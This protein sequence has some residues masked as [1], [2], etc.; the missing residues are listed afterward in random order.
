MGYFLKDE[1]SMAD[2]QENSHGGGLQVCGV[3]CM[4]LC[5][6]RLSFTKQAHWPAKQ[7]HDTTR[8]NTLFWKMDQNGS[9]EHG[10]HLKQTSIDA[11][12]EIIHAKSMF[13]GP[14]H[15]IISEVSD[16]RRHLLGILVEQGG[17]LQ[18][19]LTQVL[20][21]C[22]TWVLSRFVKVCRVCDGLN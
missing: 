17:V 11:L 12:N 10:G 4:S 3:S 2:A 19:N 15:S 5:W 22:A 16:M 7:S 21:F 9:N 18:Q 6:Q 20:G 13:L 8:D 14:I 1:L